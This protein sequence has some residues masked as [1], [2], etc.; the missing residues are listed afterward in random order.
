M[1]IYA[2]EFINQSCSIEIPHEL[3]SAYLRMFSVVTP[4]KT[5]VCGWLN[6]NGYEL[7]DGEK[8]QGTNSPNYSSVKIAE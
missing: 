1:K 8:M 5:Q 2:Y 6:K 3:K 7:A 4:T